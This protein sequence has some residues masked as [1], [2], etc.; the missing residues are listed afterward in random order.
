MFLYTHFVTVFFF[1]SFPQALFVLG[2]LVYIHAVFAKA[3]MNCLEH[4]QDTWPR[5]GILR[6][7]IVRNAPENYS[8]FNSYK[9]EYSDIQLFFQ[10][11]LAEELGFEESVKDEER[12]SPE[13]EDEE[14]IIDANQTSSS[15]LNTS[16]NVTGALPPGSEGEGLSEQTLQVTV[17]D[18]GKEISGESTSSVEEDQVILEAEK[19]KAE[20]EQD[21]V[22]ESKPELDTNE[23][24][25]ANEKESSIWDTLFRFVKKF[26]IIS[27][28]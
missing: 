25:S 27:Y 2:I 12:D 10:S 5:D 28:L 8:V 23:D 22:V 14:G 4:V 21:T 17:S 9:K 13:E 1:F 24:T 19:N 18:E 20:I 6:V 26:D 16:I 15:S 7:E 11:S 3:P